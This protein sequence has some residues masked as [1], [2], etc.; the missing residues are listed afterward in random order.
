MKSFRVLLSCLLLLATGLAEGTRLWQQ[1]K[2][3]DLEKGTAHGVAI[4][5][6]GG[7]S[8]AR[9]LTPLYTTPSTYLWGLVSDANGNA[10]A[11]AGSPARVYR[12]TPDGK[13]T[14]IFAPQ[15]LTVQALAIDSGGAIYAATSPDGKVYKIVRSGQASAKPAEGTSPAVAVDPAYTASVYFETKTKYIWALA[16]DKQGRL[17]VG[18]G[19]QGEIFR[20]ESNGKGAVFFKSDE[21]QVRVLAFD[22]VGNLIAGTD[23]SGLL[24]RITPQGEG[25]VL[26]SAPKKEITAL[27]VDP[28]GTLYAAGAGDKRGAAPAPQPNP[29][30]APLAIPPTTIVIQQ[31]TSQAAGT[32]AGVTAIPFP[33]VM[34]LGGSDIYRIAPDGAPKT[35]WSSKDELV[36]ALAF[37][38]A[39]HLL[40]GTGNKGR[41]YAIRDGEYTDLAKASANQVTAFAQ[42]P[43]GGVFAAT[44]NLGKV[45]TIG[46]NPIAEGNVRKR[47]LRRQDFLQVGTGRGLRLGKFRAARTQRQRG[48]SGPELE[49]MEEGRFS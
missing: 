24:Y 48:K 43:Q 20:V 35:I 47:C 46:A 40:A 8:L 36:Y 15:E 27:A 30:G 13:A 6:D 45:F 44:S 5:S 11:A 4:N 32:A 31:G 16:L 14:I 7:L 22:H 19:D 12:I 23:G 39:G 49:S 3:D 21:S 34:N 37:D 26:Y 33:N 29:T 41:I 17:Y 28:E 18:T 9:A 42:A 1:S 2:Y 25:F 38:Q 10:Y